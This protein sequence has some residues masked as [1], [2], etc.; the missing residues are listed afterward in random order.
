MSVLYEVL[1]SR[2]ELL[3]SRLAGSRLGQLRLTVPGRNS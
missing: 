2:E 1:P 3:V